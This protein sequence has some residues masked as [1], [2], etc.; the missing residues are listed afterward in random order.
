MPKV[1]SM[2]K[3]KGAQAVSSGR[4]Q[5]NISLTDPVH[6]WLEKAAQREGYDNATTYAAELI[7]RAYVADLAE[8]RLKQAA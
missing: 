3:K 1:E 8:P 4:N 5:R 7:R 6:D 2:V